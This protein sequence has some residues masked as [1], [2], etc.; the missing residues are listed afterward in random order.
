MALGLAFFTPATDSVLGANEA[1]SLLSNGT[2]ETDSKS[3][4]W[5]DEWPHPEGSSW[6]KEGDMRFLRLRSS[7]PGETV[8]VYRLLS[9]PSPPPPALEIRLRVRYSDI[10]RGKNAWFDGRVMSHFKN[11]EG[12]VLKPEP[13]APAFTG[14]SKDWVDKSIIVQ[15][16][17][18]ARSLELMPCLF[19]AESGTLDFARVEIFPA[20]ADQLPKPEPVIPSVSATPENPALLPPEL[21]VVGNQLLAKNGKPVD[22]KNDNDP[23]ASASK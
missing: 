4:D 1:P 2:F 23:K 14:T 21:H 10:K 3:V 8:L 16:P 6:E 15:V 12:K 7:K 5:P 13:S 11:A 22:D 18:A 9:L 19:Q 17:A 20:T